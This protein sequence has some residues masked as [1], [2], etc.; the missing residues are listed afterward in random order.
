MKV[1]SPYCQARQ[2]PAKT[3][4]SVGDVLR[5]GGWMRQDKE[6]L[7]LSSRQRLQPGNPE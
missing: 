1:S 6:T 3:A 4:G 7:M 5:Y 2:R